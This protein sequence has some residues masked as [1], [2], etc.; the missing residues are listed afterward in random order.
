MEYENDAQE[1]FLGNKDEENNVDYEINRTLRQ[2]FIYKV[3]GIVLYQILLLFITVYL[4]FTFKFFHDMLLTS[5]SMRILTLIIFLTCLLIPLFKPSIYQQVPTNY[6]LV[7]IFSLS[8][9]W[10]VAACTML[11][12]KASVLYV[13]FLTVVTVTSL[14]VYAFITKNDFTGLGSFLSTALT[15]LIVASFMQIFFPI[16]L[17]NLIVT[18]FSL[19]LFS[20]YLIY[21]VQLVVGDKE[22]KFSEDDYILA[23]LNIYLDI[24]NIFIQ[25]L[26]MFGTRN[27]N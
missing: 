5:N 3:F 23:A 4:G 10:W 9:G 11:F 7:T 26:K 13:L 14:T 27:N 17:Y 12:T 16:P 20:V 19:L 22:K 6:I 21:D 8:F 24:I 25:L 18:Y 15:L 1:P 2:G